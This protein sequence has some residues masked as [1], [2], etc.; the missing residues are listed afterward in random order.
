[1]FCVLKGQFVQ[2]Q[3]KFFCVCTKVGR[4]HYAMK[5][6][7]LRGM[8]GDGALIITMPDLT[9]A[10]TA[11]DSYWQW[12]LDTGHW[13][14]LNYGTGTGIPVSV[15]TAQHSTAPNTQAGFDTTRNIGT[16]LN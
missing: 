16:G 13:S 9:A 6:L 15:D 12:T 11:R 10:W 8:D 5:G 2:V 14:P 3:V 7:S 1:M 4:W